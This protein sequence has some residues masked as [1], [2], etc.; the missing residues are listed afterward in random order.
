MTSKKLFTM[1]SAILL[2]T[3]WMGVSALWAQEAGQETFA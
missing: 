1:A 3:C 2:L